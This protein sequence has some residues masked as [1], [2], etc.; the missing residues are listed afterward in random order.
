V[1]GPDVQG[2]RPIH[3]YSGDTVS[4]GTPRFSPDRPAAEPQNGATVPNLQQSEI[5]QPADCNGRCL[6]L[7]S[8]NV[9][10]AVLIGISR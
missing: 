10:Y 1:P 5:I 4:N 8:W 9:G 7:V 6:P 2:G 3:K